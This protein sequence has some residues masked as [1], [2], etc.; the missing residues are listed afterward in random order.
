MSESVVNSYDWS[1]VVAG[2]YGLWV[3]KYKDYTPDYNYNM[4][5]AGTPPSVKWW[6]GYTMWQ[7]TSSGRIDGYNGNLDC[8]VFY[9]TAE[10][11]KKYAAKPGPVAPPVI[12]PPVVVPPV[13]PEP[14]KPEPIS[15]VVPEPPKPP[16][17][18]NSFIIKAIRFIIKLIKLIIG[19]K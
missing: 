6:K 8:N 1:S 13:V 10:A 16:V 17:I 12:V 5:Q 11:W 9:G 15:P 4:S 14:P 19:A 7:W 18:D 2:D 3:A